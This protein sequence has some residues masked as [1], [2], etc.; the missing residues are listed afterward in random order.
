MSHEFLSAYTYFTT[1]T[2]TFVFRLAVDSLNFTFAESFLLPVIVNVAWPLA[3][4][5]TL[6]GETVA[7][8]VLLEVAFTLSPTTAQ[9]SSPV[10]VTVTVVLSPFGTVTADGLEV[11]AV[12]TSHDTGVGVAV[13][14]ASN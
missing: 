5:V 11:I 4:V 6:D 3:S 8:L 2:D 12:A 1:F 9:P 14:V 13:G 10:T 7:M